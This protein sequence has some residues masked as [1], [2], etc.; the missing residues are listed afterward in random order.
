[1]VVL[2]TIVSNIG[3]ALASNLLVNDWS[4]IF[5]N[6]NLFIKRLK[7][8]VLPSKLFLCLAVATSYRLFLKYNAIS[9]IR[10]T[11]N[12][13]TSAISSFWLKSIFFKNL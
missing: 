11:K 8:S 5:V 3:I 1:M 10:F 13:N 12:G 7:P 4:D 9:I 2:V 6:M